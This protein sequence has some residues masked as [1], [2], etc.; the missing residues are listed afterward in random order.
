MPRQFRPLQLTEVPHRVKGRLPGG[1]DLIIR[2]LANQRSGHVHDIFLEWFEEYQ[3][4][5]I[6][7][8]ILGADKVSPSP[9]SLTWSSHKGVQFLAM[10]SEHLKF[11]LVTGHTNFVRGDTQKELL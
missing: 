3:S 2:A 10:D 7:V 8:R 1:I 9:Y 4:T 11:L 6:N 5:I